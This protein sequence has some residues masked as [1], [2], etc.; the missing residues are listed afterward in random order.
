MAN[1]A[2]LDIR[3]MPDANNVHISTNHTVEPN[4]GVIADFHIANNLS[5]F[6]NVNPLTQLRPLSLV[7][8]Q[9]R[10]LLDKT[11]KLTEFRKLAQ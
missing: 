10:R 5:A 1:G 4:A 9:H 3:V 2:V 7:L 8:M 11:S 6:G